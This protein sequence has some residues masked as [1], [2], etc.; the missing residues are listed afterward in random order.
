MPFPLK[1]D[2][3][4][5][6]MTALNGKNMHSSFWEHRIRCLECMYPLRNVEW[7]N[8]VANVYDGGIRATLQHLCFN[9]DCVVVLVTKI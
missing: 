7:L 8:T 4:V 5:Y 9:D 1:G 3:L 2:V 6:C